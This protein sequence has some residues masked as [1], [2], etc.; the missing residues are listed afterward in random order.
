MYKTYESL[1]TNNW[2]CLTL[3]MTEDKSC[4][5]GCDIR[6]IEECSGGKAVY[7]HQYCEC[8]CKNAEEKYSCL[9]TQNKRKIWK[10]APECRCEC[11]PNEFRECSTGI[12][13]MFVS[14]CLLSITINNF[15]ALLFL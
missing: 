12:R 1:N 13:Y 4:E 10:R 6:D 9:S 14:V 7:N 8:D 3:N 11:H 2:K 15:I 5:C